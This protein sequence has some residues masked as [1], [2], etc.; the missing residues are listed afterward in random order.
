MGGISNFQI[1]NAITNIED[2]NLI[3][4]FVGVLPLNYMNIFIDHAA[5][6]STKG[7]YSFIIA[8]T[9]DSNKQG[10]HWRSILDV[11]PKNDIFFFDSFGLDGL[12]HFIMQDD[13]KIVEKILFGTEK[14]TRADN[15]ITLCKVRFN[16][17][18]SKNLSQ[19]ELDSLSNTAVNFS[20]LYKLLAPS[21]N[22][23]IL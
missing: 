16:L 23:I 7:K 12:K 2:N 14:M 17:S 13:R 3:S 15:K 11:E 6:V 18:A 5:M 22:Y 1:E 4:N 20:I 10:T 9:D 19:A 21:S 8:I